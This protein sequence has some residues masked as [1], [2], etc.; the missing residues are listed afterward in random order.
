M[1]NGKECK[2]RKATSSCFRVNAGALLQRSF[3]HASSRAFRRAWP[4]GFVRF[5]FLN[6]GTGTASEELAGSS[7]TLGLGPMLFD[8]QPSHPLSRLA[9]INVSFCSLDDRTLHEDVPRPSEEFRIAQ[10]S[11]RS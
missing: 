8:Q 4:V 5:G 3:L 11:F 2:E 6:Q 10:A 1:E 9:G 7:W